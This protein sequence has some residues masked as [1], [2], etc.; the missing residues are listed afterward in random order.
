M[1]DVAAGAL[2]ELARGAATNATTLAVD[3]WE[4]VA[5]HTSRNG[6]MLLLLEAPAAPQL[7]AVL[8]RSAADLAPAVTVHRQSLH[9]HRNPFFGQHLRAKGQV[10]CAAAGALIVAFRAEPGVTSVAYRRRGVE[11]RAAVDP[12]TSWCAILDWDD[13]TPLDAFISV[14]RAGAVVPTVSPLFPYSAEFAADSYDAFWRKDAGSNQERHTWIAHAFTEVK[15]E[16]FKK[17]TFALLKAFDP[18]RHRTGIAQFGAGP[19]YANGHWFYDELE[20][21]RDIAVE[22]LLLAME[23][24]RPESLAPDLAERYHKLRRQLAQRAR[25]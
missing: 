3:V 6:A 15:P 24:E 11:Q 16:A 10:D 8:F 17:L 20:R 19:M 9:H 21:D 4:F 1:P 23:M 25:T 5:L 7:V 12:A 18:Q 22:T 14:E 2:L 13:A